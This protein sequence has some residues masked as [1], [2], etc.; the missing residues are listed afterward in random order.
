LPEIS[1][2]IFRI[3]F[4]LSSLEFGDKILIQSELLK[5]LEPVLVGIGLDELLG[6][7]VPLKLS[8]Q[9]T[10]VLPDNINSLC[11]HL[12]ARLSN[13]NET[14][15]VS[16]HHFLKLLLPKIISLYIKELGQI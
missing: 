13:T 4:L 15:A 12:Y 7:D 8:I 9:L 11:N 14:I 5:T 6:F 2:R 1:Q 16:A 3:Y 10:A